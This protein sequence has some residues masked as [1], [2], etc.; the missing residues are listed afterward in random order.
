M[1][2]IGRTVR[3]AVVLGLGRVFHERRAADSQFRPLGKAP[4]KKLIIVRRECNVGI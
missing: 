1:G 2:E 4:E 3:V